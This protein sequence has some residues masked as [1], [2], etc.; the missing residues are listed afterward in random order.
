MQCS[1]EPGEE[2]GDKGSSGDGYRAVAMAAATAEVGRA[3][4][5]R[6]F[7]EAANHSRGCLYKGGT[8]PRGL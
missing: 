3:A 1:H 2:G 7:G 8:V 4:A 6:R 5:R